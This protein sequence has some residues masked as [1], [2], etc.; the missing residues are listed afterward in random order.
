MTYKTSEER[1]KKRR[2]AVTRAN[3]KY[4]ESDRYK[5]YKKEYNKQR[6]EKIKML[7]EDI[8][9]GEDPA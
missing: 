7:R 9:H 2:E 5:E 6:N 3:L 1:D 4:Q 8:Q